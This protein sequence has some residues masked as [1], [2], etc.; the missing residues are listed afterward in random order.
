MRYVPA[1]LTALVL[2]ALILPAHSPL[3]FA[4]SPIERAKFYQW[5]ALPHIASITGLFAP[6]S[7]A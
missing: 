4:A 1:S 7:M 2:D 3:L 6:Y 5:S